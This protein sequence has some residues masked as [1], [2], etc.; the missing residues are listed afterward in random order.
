M[1]KERRGVKM[2]VKQSEERKGKN[3]KECGNLRKIE[4]KEKEGMESGDPV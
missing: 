4:R 3:Q 2:E 1:E